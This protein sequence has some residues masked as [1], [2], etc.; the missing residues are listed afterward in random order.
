VER[1]W[2]SCYGSGIVDLSF[3]RVSPAKLCRECDVI[4][5][6]LG[7]AKRRFSS[8]LGRGRR[9]VSC[10]G[11]L[12]GRLFELSSTRSYVEKITPIPMTGIIRD[13]EYFS[14]NFHSAYQFPP[15]LNQ[16]ATFFGSFIQV[17]GYVGIF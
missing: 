7:G 8:C 5:G 4:G 3:P 17:F 14:L 15:P 13:Q 12:G 6:K 1:G 16:A 10:V 9:R 2:S 11:E